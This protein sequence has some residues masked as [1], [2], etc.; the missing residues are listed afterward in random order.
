VPELQS[1]GSLNTSIELGAGITKAK[2]KEI[3]PYMG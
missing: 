1:L 2:A 3:I